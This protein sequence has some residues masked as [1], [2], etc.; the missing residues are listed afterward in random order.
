MTTDGTA[1]TPKELILSSDYKHFAADMMGVATV[2]EPV[3]GGPI[4]I[5]AFKNVALPGPATFADAD[6]DINY[7]VAAL[8]SVDLSL[9][10]AKGLVDML[11][12]AIEKLETVRDTEPQHR[13]E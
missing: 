1:A 11:S 10:S 2:G 13:G 4:L 8:A 9:E 3:K 5:T 12:Q 7:K 6:Y